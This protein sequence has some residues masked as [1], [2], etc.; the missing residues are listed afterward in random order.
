MASFKATQPRANPP[1]CWTCN[2]RLYAG[3]RIYVLVED[4]DGNQHPAHK[5]CAVKES[6]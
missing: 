5:N 2:K 6:R 1:I 3:G 4:E